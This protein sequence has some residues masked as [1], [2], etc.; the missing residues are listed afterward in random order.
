MNSA[1]S[2]IG[3]LAT[4][5]QPFSRK[6]GLAVLLPAIGVWLVLTACFMFGTDWL[7]NALHLGA[8]VPDPAKLAHRLAGAEGGMGGVPAPGCYVGGQ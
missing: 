7:A 6:S 2:S 8:D 1:Y 5:A 3:V 4:M